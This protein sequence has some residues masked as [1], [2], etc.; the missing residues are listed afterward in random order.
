MTEVRMQK[1]DFRVGLAG[2]RERKQV[3]SIKHSAAF[4]RARSVSLSS[5]DQLSL[6]NEPKLSD[7]GKSKR[8]Y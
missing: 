6:M 1:E 7:R 4:D 3:I 5:H 2:D 8:T